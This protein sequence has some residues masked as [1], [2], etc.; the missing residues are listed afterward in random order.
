MVVPLHL[1]PKKNSGSRFCGDYRT[2]NAR[3]FSDKYPVPHT[4]NFSHRLAGG[5]NFSKIDFV[6]VYHQIPVHPD[7]IQKTALTTPFGLFELPFMSFGLRN[8]PEHSKIS[9]MKSLKT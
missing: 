5:N 6:R 1:V 4:R 2:P 7:D 8:A 3:T 9:W